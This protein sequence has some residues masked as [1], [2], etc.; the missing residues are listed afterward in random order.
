[1]DVSL[2]DH[3][4]GVKARETVLEPCP[5]A[6]FDGRL[7]FANGLSGVDDYPIK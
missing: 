6:V 4:D 2:V 3:C 5:P 1:M 7:S